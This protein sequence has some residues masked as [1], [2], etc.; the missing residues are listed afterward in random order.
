MKPAV[1]VGRGRIACL[2]PLLLAAVGGLW[3]SSA[4]AQRY[5]SRDL[6]L[7][8]GHL[9]VDAGPRWLWAPPGTFEFGLKDPNPIDFNFGLSIAPAS[10]VQL[11]AVVVPLRLSPDTDYQQPS[12]HG[13]FGLSTGAVQSAFLVNL[14]L[15]TD[16]D[17]EVDLG[18]PVQIRLADFLRLD[19]AVIA[20]ALFDDFRMH[21][22]FPAELAVGLGQKVFLGVGLGLRVVELIGDADSDVF[23]P[24][25]LFGGYSF[26]QGDLR[27]QFDLGDAASD[28]DLYRLMTRLELWFGL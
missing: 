19:L 6:V 17:A 22:W 2:V 23:V 20:E 11:G 10:S 3:A 4:T 21:L 25:S 8:S 1:G 16:N 9:R 27:L 24:F 28:V 26:A 7:P 14:V 12:L 18:F 5:P 13:L 15:P